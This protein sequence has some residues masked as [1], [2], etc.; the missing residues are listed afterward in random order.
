MKSTAKE[1]INEAQV[2][3]TESCGTVE[4]ISSIR[5]I[6]QKYIEHQKYVYHNFIDFKKA[7]DRVWHE[8]L[9]KT[10]LKQNIRPGMVSVIKSLYDHA[11]KYGVNRR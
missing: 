6:K 1:L 7:F 8:A 11:I 10:T 2:R 9:W 4:Q 3:F 5:L